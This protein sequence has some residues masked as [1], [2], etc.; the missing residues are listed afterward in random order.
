MRTRLAE[1]R[2]NAES[3]TEVSRWVALQ[4]PQV[5]GKF[6][7]DDSNAS[8]IQLGEIRRALQYCG[9]FTELPRTLGT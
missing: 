6:H 3:L 5:L 8:T 2:G 7:G 4:A 9:P 1:L